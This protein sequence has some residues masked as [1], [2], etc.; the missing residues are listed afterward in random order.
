VDVYKKSG[1]A[2]STFVETKNFSIAASEKSAAYFK[3]FPPSTGDYRLSVYTKN[4]VFINDGYVKFNPKNNSS[5]GT[6]N[7]TA[8]SAFYA[9]SKI[10]FSSDEDKVL[11]PKSY[12]T[13]FTISKE[14]GYI[15]AVVDNSPNQLNTDQIIVDIWKKKGGKYETFVETKRYNV[16]NTY[17]YTYFKYSFFDPGEYKISIFTKGEVWINTGYI[18]VKKK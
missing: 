1:D 13:E 12:F 11:D 15:Y 3:Y 8:S 16:T 6:E 7:T 14:G 9:K 18:I 5:A 2:Y 4:K 10:N 17:D